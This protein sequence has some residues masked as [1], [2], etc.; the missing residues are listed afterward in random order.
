MA[1]LMVTLIDEITIARPANQVF[2][3]VTQPDLWHE[4]HPA[5]T[6]A[7][8]PRKPLQVGD[9][10]REI[11]S[12]KYPLVSV[13]RHTEYAVS[14][15]KKNETWEVRGKSSLFDLIIHYDFIPDGDT[16]LFKRTLT[17]DVK[18]PL[19]WFEPVLVRPKIR[20][21]SAHA[22]RNLKALLESK[23]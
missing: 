8:L 11:I 4:W 20:S 19:Q 10:F 9:A 17:Y 15:S 5:S 6:S 14:I 7:V 18:G 12:V 21:Q 3:Y 1:C 13:R 22:L 23:P 16:T 2:A